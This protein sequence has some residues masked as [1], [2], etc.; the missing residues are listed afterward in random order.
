MR[1]A[2]DKKNNIK[3]YEDIFIAIKQPDVLNKIRQSGMDKGSK[4]NY[5]IQNLPQVNHT[6][7]AD[8]LFKNVLWIQ[9][10]LSNN[11]GGENYALVGDLS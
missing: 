11:H 8:F 6:I 5:N 2:D 3:L 7:R 10:L 9:E 1:K 4:E